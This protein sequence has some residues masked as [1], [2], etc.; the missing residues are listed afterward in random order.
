M[1]KVVNILLALVLVVGST[2]ISVSKHYCMG[3]LR[4]VAVN[5]H[6][7]GCD[8][9]SSMPID[10]CE[11]ETERFGVEDELQLTLNSINTEASLF[12]LRIIDYSDVIAGLNQINSGA[13]GN[14]D[15][16][17]PLLPGVHIFVRVQSFLL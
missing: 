16:D 2:G 1:K 13:I 7:K 14:S 5:Q 10:C 9:E 11:D 12:L 15:V 6:A 3:L 8:S 4:D 17:P